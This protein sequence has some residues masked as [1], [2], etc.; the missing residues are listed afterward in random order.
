MMFVLLLFS[1]RIKILKA[2]S[3][4][5]HRSSFAFFL[6][7]HSYAEVVLGGYVINRS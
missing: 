4:S 5:R 1:W 7:C 3:S 6:Y 2:S